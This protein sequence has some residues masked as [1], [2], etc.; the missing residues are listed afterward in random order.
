MT[1]VLFAV[2]LILGAVFL[3]SVVPKF[4]A[5]RQFASGIRALHEREV[6]P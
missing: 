1:F 5:P 6:I 4:A 3:M 2:C